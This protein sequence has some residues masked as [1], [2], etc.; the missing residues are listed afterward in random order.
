MYIS[1]RCGL[2]YFLAMPDPITITSLA[3]AIIAIVG[4]AKEAYDVA[5]DAQGLPKAFAVIHAQM[6]LTQHTLSLIKDNCE[7]DRNEAEILKVLSACKED[8]EK[9]SE[10][11]KKVCPGD[12]DGFLDRYKKALRSMKLGRRDKVELLWRSILEYLQTLH[13]YDASRR[14]I[15]RKELEEA[16][17]KIEAVSLKRYGI[18][19]AIPILIPNQ[20]PDSLPESDGGDTITTHG[21]GSNVKSSGINQAFAPVTYMGQNMTFQQPPGTN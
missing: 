7:S 14:L 6:P 15:P 10:I 1:S 12:K 3:A 16:I 13:Q 18:S 4:A 19:I 5:K 20:I 2:F 21:Q 8:A 11:F 9:L 17:S